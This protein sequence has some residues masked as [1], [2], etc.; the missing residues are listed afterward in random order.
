MHRQYVLLR[1]L[2]STP[3]GLN[4]VGT[5]GPERLTAGCLEV[6]FSPVFSQTPIVFCHSGQATDSSAVN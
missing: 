3:K 4:R 6:W 5:N 2:S 1:T